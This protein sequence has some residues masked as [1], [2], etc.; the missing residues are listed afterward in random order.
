MRTAPETCQLVHDQPPQA[1]AA[2]AM[3]GSIRELGSDALSPGVGIP[4]GPIDAFEF[5]MFVHDVPSGES[6]SRVP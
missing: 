4:D 6:A 1:L 5:P 2:G 3:I